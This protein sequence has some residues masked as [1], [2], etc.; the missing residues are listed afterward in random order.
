M[1]AAN[2]K[3]WHGTDSRRVILVD[4]L[5]KKLS[6]GG[7][8]LISISVLYIAFFVINYFTPALAD[9]FY[10]M[11]H[12]GF[13]LSEE[14]NSLSVL[15]RSITAFYKSWGGRFIGYALMVFFNIIPPVV[16]DLLNSLAYVLLVYLIY[17]ICNL[18]KKSNLKLF[19]LVNIFIWLFVPDYGQV[20]FW[21]AGSAN[22]LYP[23]IFALLVLL[24][25]RKYTL[26]SGNYFKSIWW[27]VPALL[28][29][30]I[31]GAGMENISGGMIV[32]LTLY[33]IYFYK[34][35]EKKIPL[36]LAIVSLYTGCII[37]FLVLFFAPG[38]SA[39]AGAQE[40]VGFIF[41]CFI[42]CYYWIFFGLGIFM[43]MLVLVWC[44]YKKFFT[45]KRSEMAQSYIYYI[46]SILSAFCLILTP[47]IAE[48]AWFISTVYGVVAAGMLFAS[49]DDRQKEE[50]EK[51]SKKISS[52]KMISFII[53]VCGCIFCLVSIA[54]TAICSYEMHKQSVQRGE[55]ILEQRAAGNMDISVPII[56]Y[57]YPF[58]SKHD[59]LSGLSDITEDS[60]YWI[61][62]A[63][64]G[65]Y[66]VNTITGYTQ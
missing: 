26:E 6:G 4:K 55:Y 62:Q 3:I 8:W 66:G 57:K 25:F 9:D 5:K 22:Y 47:T 38:N 46:A 29:G 7:Y 36:N 43:V 54:D 13:G 44:G 42:A 48:R 58:R 50:L 2:S 53:T 49:A 40:S 34:K 59:A 24:I 64:A 28:L 56:S 51:N 27:V 63:L 31:A 14:I 30:F 61:N 23:A 21:T 65:Y 20:M 1:W 35:K 19:L 33:I 18:G 15:V 39:R 16:F 17:K 10:Y 37:G 32:I 45:I 52:V 12:L 41:K 60:S 11:R